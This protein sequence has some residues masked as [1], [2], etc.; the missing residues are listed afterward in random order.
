[1]GDR[2]AS[3]DALLNLSDRTVDELRGLLDEL[4]EEEQKVS[5]RR[6][7]LHGKIDILRAELVRRLKE[8]RS[9][10]KGDILGSDIDRLIEILANDLRGVSRFDV[11]DDDVWDEEDDE[12]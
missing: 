4:Y 7:V 10:G 11:T 9:E 3:D 2:G 8:D 6:R 5:Y 1:M 12:D